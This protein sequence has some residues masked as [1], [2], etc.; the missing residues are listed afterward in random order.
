M[1]LF[2]FRFLAWSLLVVI[3]LTPA[4]TAA[5]T[6]NKATLVT[7]WFPQPQFAGYYMALEKGIYKK[8]GLDIDIISGGSKTD[9]ALL[10]KTGKARFAIL[11][12]I[13]A[14]E[15]KAQGMELVNV[16]QI[17]QNS[18]IEFVVRKDS[19][20]KTLKDF[21]NRPVVIWNNTRTSQ[22]LGFF[23][24][25][26]ITPRIIRSLEATEFFLKGAADG[27]AV[28]H[29]NEYKSLLNHGIHPQEIRV[30]KLKDLGLDFPE[31]GIYCMS[32]T[33]AADPELVKRFVAVALEGWEYALA[34][35]EETVTLFKKIRR[36][37]NL[38]ANPS[39]LKWTMQQMQEMLLPGNGAVFRGGRLDKSDHER[40]VAFLIRTGRI[41][42]TVPY[43]DFWGG[44]R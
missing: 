32:R 2:P 29:Y 12:L 35:P 1:P 14:L 10:L 26:G 16:A 11:N 28:M 38:P 36:E 9:S 40:A 3:M 34:H 27:C 4:L 17:F 20:I 33:I 37:N 43:D 18:S 15:L 5:S 41:K 19:G 25:H 6:L 23:K 24:E 44:G 42:K 8:F 30:F 7:M 13:H 22:T 39:H 21:Q 31:D